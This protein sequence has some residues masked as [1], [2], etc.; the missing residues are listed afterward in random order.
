LRKSAA[1]FV[2]GEA[3][4]APATAWVTCPACGRP[5]SAEAI[6]RGD[7]DPRAPWES[8]L[9]F[10]LWPAT[11]GLLYVLWAPSVWWTLGLAAAVAVVVLAI[12]DRWARRGVGLARAV[13]LA[14]VLGCALAVRVPQYRDQ[15]AAA[16]EIMAL[17]GSVEWSFDKMVVR[18]YLAR[19][20]ADDGTL[21]LVAR[22]PRLELLHLGSTNVTDAGLA[23]LGGLRSLSHL[24]LSE[25][26]ITDAGLETLRTLGSLSLVNL[27]GTATSPEAVAA[28]REALPGLEV[29][30]SPE[31]PEGR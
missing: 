31:L 12:L 28:L 4:I 29:V 10:L 1:A 11:S 5:I 22:F 19:T 2:L 8:G 13:A 14:A 16:G 20:A 3:G 17:G 23:H 21:A 26:K 30:G 7:Y 15:L 18:A 27:N 24:F 9:G 6:V 25:T